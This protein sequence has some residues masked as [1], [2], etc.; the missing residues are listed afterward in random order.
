[1]ARRTIAIDFACE[2]AV[3]AASAGV[4]AHA[5]TAYLAWNM[6]PMEATNVAST[7]SALTTASSTARLR[8]GYKQAAGQCGSHQESHNPF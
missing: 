4:A 1:M 3:H 5:R 6:H 7:K 2:T 8:I